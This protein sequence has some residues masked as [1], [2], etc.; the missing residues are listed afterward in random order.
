MQYCIYLRKSRADI[1]AETRDKE[2]TLARHEKTLLELSKHLHLS[3][4][5]I[6]REVVSGDTISARPVM[7]QLLSEVEQGVWAGVLVMEVERLARGDTIDQGI[8]AQAFKF[9]NTK[10]ITPIK[11]Y[12]PNNE[13]DEEYFEFGLFMSR[14]EYKTI[15]RRLQ[16]G[17]FASVKE[18]KYVANC[19]PYGY[20]RKKIEH[21]KGFTLMPEPEQAQVVKMI[22]E[23]YTQGEKLLDGTFR[24]LGV[25]LIVRRLNSL[26]IFPQR[27]EIWVTSSVR[28]ILINPVYAGKI[29]WNWRPI[30]KSVEG[31]L[32]V[33]KRPRNA[34]DK[35]LITHGLHE[36]II[37]EAT[38]KLAQYYMHQNPPLP[39]VEHKAIKNPLAGIIICGKC[40]HR[41]VRRSHQCN[42]EDSLICPITACGNISSPLRLVEEHLLDSLE[43]WLREYKIKLED[44]REKR[45]QSQIE[46]VKISLAKLDENLSKL[47]NQMESLYDFLEQGV[48]TK[49][50]FAERLT[51]LTEKLGQTKVEKTSLQKKLESEFNS[52]EKKNVF[53]P[54]IKHLLELYRLLPTP[55]TKNDI[56]KEVLEKVV[57]TKTVNGRWHNQADEFSLVLYPKFPESH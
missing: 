4:S 44:T 43:Q 27:G 33:K 51:Y 19:P 26:K 21:D 1:E 16:R 55:Q 17:R 25:S 40:G 14:R 36:A 9:S 35:C 5:Q 12:D 46:V 34:A 32:V 11:T 42:N 53:I 6:Y 8:V 31:G 38:W 24:R 54:E 28:D 47:E 23:L 45:Q 15:N 22:Y 7:Q 37:D 57:Y 30:L 50:K 49:D 2:E 48:Y 10:I 20:I 18:G 29:R 52:N 3:I 56:L 39:A 13:F 41:M